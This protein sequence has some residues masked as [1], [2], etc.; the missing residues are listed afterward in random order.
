[1]RRDAAFSFQSDHDLRSLRERLNARGIH[2]WIERD[3]DNYGEYLSTRAHADYGF[4]KIYKDDQTAGYCFTIKFTC[5]RPTIDEEFAELERI[6]LD[7]IL[8]GVEAR[9][10]QKRETW[11]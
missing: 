5:D 2:T 1:M 11:D 10:I 8:P 3:N 7:E 4:Y 6:A 9:D